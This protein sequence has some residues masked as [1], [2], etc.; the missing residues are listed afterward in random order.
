MLPAT[1]QRWLS[2]LFAFYFL[3]STVYKLSSH[4]FAE[5][6]AENVQLLISYEII[7]NS[8][9]GVTQYIS[10]TNDSISADVNIIRQI[11]DWRSTF[12]F[13]STSQYNTVQYNILLQSCQD[14]VADPD[15]SF[16]GHEVPKALRGVGCGVCIPSPLFWSILMSKCVSHVYTCI[17]YFHSHQYKPEYD[18]FIA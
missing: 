14:A 17:A 1:R 4:T 10:Y 3:S 2:R 16:G 13:R 12:S 5:L 8:D 7:N 6:L 11:H 18:C 15:I 9:S